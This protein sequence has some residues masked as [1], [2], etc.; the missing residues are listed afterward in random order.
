[1]KI[2]IYKNIKTVV[3]TKNLDLPIVLEYIKSGKF[4]KQISAIRLETDKTKRNLLKQNL[5]Y[6]KEKPWHKEAFWIGLFRF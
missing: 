6:N 2:S 1:M 4:D 3:P 5:P